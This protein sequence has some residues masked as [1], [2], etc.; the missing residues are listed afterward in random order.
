MNKSVFLIRAVN[1]GG[2]KLPMAELRQIAGD[3]GATDVAT[4][5]ASGNL[6]C[7]PPGSA[8]EFAPAL[9]SALTER[10]GWSREV[11]ARSAEDLEQA[12]AAHPFEVVEPKFSYVHC[13]VD[14]PEPER[15]EAFYERDLD[16][17]EVRVI[18][19]DVHMRYP[20]GAGTSKLTA[21]VLARSLG[22][23]GTARNMRTVDELIARAR[24]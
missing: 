9:E 14:A 7:S 3:L 13:L 18:G 20:N 12:V 15:V 23:Q 6:I 4:Y 11:I 22:V 8:S 21:A 19:D 16:G 17:A 10:Y 24:S 1:V 2:T 5:V